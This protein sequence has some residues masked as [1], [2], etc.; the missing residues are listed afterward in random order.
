MSNR[1]LGWWKTASNPQRCRPELT[2]VI[3]TGEFPQIFQPKSITTYPEN[4]LGKVCPSQGGEL[5][6]Q[7]RQEQP[8]M[9][10]RA[11]DIQRQIHELSSR[12]MQLWSIVSLVILVLTGG[13][14]ALVAP[15]LTISQRLIHIEQ[16]YLPQLF[17]GL[18]CLIVLFNI[19]LLSQ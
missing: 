16:G 10:A 1:S 11:E 8:S 7:V 18:I 9:L 4:H 13:F 2:K 12:D 17:F 14:L 3:Q 19:Y 15:N 6:S 5:M